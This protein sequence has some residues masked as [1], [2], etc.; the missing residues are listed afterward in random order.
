M[1]NNVSTYR[2][3]LLFVTEREGQLDNNFHIE[4]NCQLS[5]PAP[6][7]YFFYSSEA[8][9]QKFKL[10]N[11][12]AG[13]YRFRPLSPPDKDK[14]GWRQYIST[15]YQDEDKHVESIE[16]GELLE[17]TELD[18]A[19]KAT[20][21][22]GISPAIFVNIILYNA[23]YEQQIKIDWEN[24]IIHLINPNL[25]MIYSQITIYVDLEYMNNQLKI[26]DNSEKHRLH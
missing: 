4:M 12:I 20:R 22:S 25:K 5:I 13:L 23:Q 19:M 14:N 21:D 11:D 18:R 2:F 6:Q 24:M 1:K 3:K 17:G 9:E 26:L 8:L 7:E 15:E 10:Q 16:L